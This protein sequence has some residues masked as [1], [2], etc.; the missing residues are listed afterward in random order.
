MKRIIILF[1]FVFAVACAQSP[2][3][4]ADKLVKEAIKK[5]LFV[6]NSYEAVDTQIDS[7]FSPYQDPEFVDICL[8]SC[9][10]GKELDEYESDMR[11][12]KSSMSIW[13]DSRHRSSFAQEQYNQAKSKY[14]KSK[15]KYDALY[16]RLQKMRDVLREKIAKGSDFIG[17]HVYHRYRANSNAGYSILSGAH[18]IISEDFSSILGMWDDEAISIYNEF[19]AQS[20][21]IAENQE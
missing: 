2:E 10:L 8:N 18:F 6:P 4:K 11:S 5:T 7:A 3:K 20:A 9:E 13:Q 16:S 19:L 21:S 15:E 12:A 17:Y 14:D 1:L